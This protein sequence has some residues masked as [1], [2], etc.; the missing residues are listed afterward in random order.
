MDILADPEMALALVKAAADGS[1]LPKTT[2]QPFP[3]LMA[4]DWT[5]HELD[6][7]VAVAEQ[8][9]DMSNEIIIKKLEENDFHHEEGA[10]LYCLLYNRHDQQEKEDLFRGA[11]V[12]PVLREKIFTGTQYKAFNPE[13]IE[14]ERRLTQ[15]LIDKDSDQLAVLLSVEIQGNRKRSQALAEFLLNMINLG[16]DNLA[17]RLLAHLPTAN[18]GQLLA[19]LSPFDEPLQKVAGLFVSQPGHLF[20]AVSTISDRE[21]SGRLMEQLFTPLT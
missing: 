18:L 16:L 3:T 5:G 6:F 1:H 8:M 19:C 20:Q 13:Q 15:A 10:I 2:G 14:I 11:F 7:L 17:F 12:S 21:I 4:Q 9:Q